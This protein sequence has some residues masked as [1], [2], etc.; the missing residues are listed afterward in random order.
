M[1]RF[2]CVKAISLLVKITISLRGLSTF[3]VWGQCVNLTW[4]ARPEQDAKGVT[5]PHA[6][7]ILLRGCL[8]WGQTPCSPKRFCQEKRARIPTN[9]GGLTPFK[10]PSGQDAKGVNVPERLGN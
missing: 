3:V 1:I 9:P 8:K 2:A 5:T 4:G 10:T 6:L 7:R